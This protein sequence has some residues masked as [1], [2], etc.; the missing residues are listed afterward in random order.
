[1][2]KNVESVIVPELNQGQ[3]IHEIERLAKDKEDGKIIPIQRV[4]GELITPRDILKKIK[5]EQ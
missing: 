5:E 1:M 3:F 2:L 4:D